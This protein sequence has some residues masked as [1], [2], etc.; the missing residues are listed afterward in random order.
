MNTWVRL[1]SFPKN[2]KCFPTI[3]NLLYKYEQYAYKPLHFLSLLSDQ[4]LISE[5]R[6][7]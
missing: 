3:V 2:S 6:K 4:I 1:Q 7:P 5:R